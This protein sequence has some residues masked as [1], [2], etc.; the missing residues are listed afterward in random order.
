MGHGHH[1]ILQENH[2][3]LHLV[4][5]KPARKGFFEFR[6]EKMTMGD[7]VA[8]SDVDKGESRLRFYLNNEADP[9]S[10]PDSIAIIVQDGLIR[11]VILAED[12]ESISLTQKAGIFSIKINGQY[13]V[14]KLEN[15]NFVQGGDDPSNGQL[16]IVKEISCVVDMRN[17][18]T[19]PKWTKD[20]IDDWTNSSSRFRQILDVKDA[21]EPRTV[22]DVFADWARTSSIGLPSE[23]LLF[24]KVQLNKLDR[25][26]EVL[27]WV[28]ETATL[29]TTFHAMLELVKSLAESANVSKEDLSTRLQPV[30][31]SVPEPQLMRVLDSL[32]ASENKN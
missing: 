16:G 17:P 24:A 4:A 13:K 31:L 6:L 11:F 15:A 30:V 29:G 18:I 2:V 25:L 26:C 19:Q 1:S 28:G 22:K 20:N 3:I 12:I 7:Y 27:E 10:K 32:W 9:E 14:E 5:P 23:R 21:D 8:E